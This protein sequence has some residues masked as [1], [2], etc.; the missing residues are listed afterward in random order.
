MILCRVLI[1]QVLRAKAR[2][3]E[4]DWEGA[5]IPTLPQDRKWVEA[6]S[7]DRMPA[8][9]QAGLLADG[10]TGVLSAVGAVPVVGVAC[11][12][13]KCSKESYPEDQILVCPWE[14]LIVVSGVEA[15]NPGVRSQESA[16][17]DITARPHVS[18][19]SAMPK[20]KT[21][22]FWMLSPEFSILIGNSD[23]I[24]HCL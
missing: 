8:C 18:W 12:D 1:D 5:T 24:A 16:Q 23:A 17:K 4:E 20:A 3:Q 15:S 11:E 10:A 9:P 13:R 19:F 2:E 6:R 14:G 22:L 21:S 7:G